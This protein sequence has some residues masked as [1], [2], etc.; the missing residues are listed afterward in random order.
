MHD[1]DIELAYGT[2]HCAGG[3]FVGPPF[4]AHGL[5]DT[6]TAEHGPETA[7]AEPQ[8][9]RDFLDSAAAVPFTQQHFVQELAET[10]LGTA[11]I[12]ES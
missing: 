8:A 3:P 9:A 2:I 10:L 1:L 5:L 11:S 6:P 12:S 4:S 7:L